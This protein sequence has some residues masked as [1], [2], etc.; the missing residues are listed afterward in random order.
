MALPAE[1]SSPNHDGSLAERR[2]VVI[3]STRGGASSL[4][5][6]YEATV[7]H[8]HDPAPGGDARRAVS[9]HAI[10]GP[11][12]QVH[13]PV[14]AEVIAWH[15]RTYNA[16]HRGLELIQPRLGDRIPDEAIDE[17]ARI[18]ASWWRADRAAGYAW[19]L[20]WGIERGLCEHREIPPGIADGKSDIGAPFD[21][22]DFLQ[23]VKLYAEQ[24]E[25]M[26]AE[27]K[28]KV[29]EHLAVAWGYA[30][31]IKKVGDIAQSAVLNEAQRAIR[32]RIIAVKQTLGIE[33]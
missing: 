18:I 14:S 29:L 21:R 25:D 9:C 30:D 2:G 32:E 17:A 3:H 19:P 15:A 23:R 28:A 24:G 20:A 1:Y 6:E 16:H 22:T 33:G 26:T 10:V 13:R 11:N 31:E 12:R 5:S 8:C 4:Q 7:R 27:Q